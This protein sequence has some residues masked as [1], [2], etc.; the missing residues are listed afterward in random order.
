MILRFKTQNVHPKDF[1]MKKIHLICLLFA[2]LFAAVGF[3]QPGEEILVQKDQKEQ[4]I[5]EERMEI[6]GQI[7][8]VM[9]IGEDTLIVADLEEAAVSSPRKFKNNDE[10]RHYLRMRY[11]AT[12]V[13]PYAVEAIKV[14]REVEYWS[15]GK[16]K[17]QRKKHIKR[18][19]KDLKENFQDPLKNLTRTQGRILVEMIEREIETP[20]FYVIKE[21]KGPIKATW[22]QTVGRAWGY[23]LKEGYDPEK[24]PILEGILATLKIQHEV[25]EE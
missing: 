17:R 7:V 22:W 15:Q 13:Y 20:V 1:F 12:K 19:Q 14:F 18:L 23:D 6:Q 8:R 16:K 2:G 10:Y 3:A 11:H 21:L 25:K 24:D 9:I 4:D 5:R